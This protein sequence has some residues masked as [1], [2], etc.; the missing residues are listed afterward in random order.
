MD[1]QTPYTNPQAI[2]TPQF[3]P[4]YLGGFP[5]PNMPYLPFHQASFQPTSSSIVSNNLLE[6]CEWST[7]DTALALASLAEAVPVVTEQRADEQASEQA[8]ARIEARFCRLEDRM[9]AFEER[10]GGFGERT[11]SLED[12]LGGVEE[13]MQ[14]LRNE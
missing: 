1:Y 12:K 2:Q 4:A 5:Y 11:G 9:R 10:C 13:L 7:Q 8:T 6:D 14:N 3:N